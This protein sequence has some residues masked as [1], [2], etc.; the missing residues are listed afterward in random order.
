LQREEKGATH[1]GDLGKARPVAQKGWWGK[2]KGRSNGKQFGDQGNKGKTRETMRT[3]DNRRGKKTHYRSEA[4][5]Q[6][7]LLV[8]KKK[9]KL[10]GD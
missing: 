2:G 8:G 1:I 4:E 6:S 3:E 7:D 9:K 10:G 5:G